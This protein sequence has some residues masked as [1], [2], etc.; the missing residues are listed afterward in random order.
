MNDK[1]K[2]IAGLAVAL[3]ALTFPFWYTRAAGRAGSPPDLELPN[4]A[5]PCVEDRET[6][7]AHHMELLDRWRDAVVRKGE[8]TY[9]SESSGQR[10]PMSLSKTCM[11]CH[12]NRETFCDKC[13][14]YAN[15]SSAIHCWDCHHVKPK[16]FVVP[17]L[18]GNPHEI[19]PE[20]GTTNGPSPAWHTER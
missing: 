9:V 13:H 6:M 20:G 12:T 4:G 5:T 3:V 10:F 18:A 15:V 19:P 17:A 1:P 2:I 14:E 8:M 7:R 11:G 16:E